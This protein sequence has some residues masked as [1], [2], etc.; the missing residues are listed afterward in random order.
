MLYARVKASGH[1][2]EYDIFLT[3]TQD[4]EASA[5]APQKLRQ[6]LRELAGFINQHSD[7]K[8]PTLLMGDLNVNGFN[9]GF[10]QEM[11]SLLNKPEDL[12]PGVITYDENG[13]F[14]SDKPTRPI[15][16]PQRHK[17]GQNLDYFFVWRGS[18]FHSV[19]DKTEVV[20][21]QSS[22]GR[23]ISDH[24][25]LKAQQKEVGAFTVTIKQAVVQ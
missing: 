7:P 19:Y 6:Q 24:Y 8:T 11:L 15:D 12:L 16:D 14:Q 20:V 25:G 22:P 4:A 21:W 17:H 18:N 10:Y 3:H 2:T 5:D 1:P 9:A 23:D 13:S